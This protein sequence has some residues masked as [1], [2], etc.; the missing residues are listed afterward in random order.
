MNKEN[1]TTRTDTCEYCHQTHIEMGANGYSVCRS[2]HVVVGDCMIDGIHDLGEAMKSLEIIDLEQEKGK[3]TNICEQCHPVAIEVGMNGYS[4][5]RSDHVV[6]GDCIID[7]IHDLGDAMK[8]LKDII[9][10][11]KNDDRA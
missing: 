5:C 11:Q 1:N 10:K 6:V 8:I 9:A 2:D 7:G 4:L 3:K